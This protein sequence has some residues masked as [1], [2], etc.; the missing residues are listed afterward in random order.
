MQPRLEIM[1]RILKYTETWFYAWRWTQQHMT[2][3]LAF[4]NMNTNYDMKA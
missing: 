2:K 4:L 1:L 3:L